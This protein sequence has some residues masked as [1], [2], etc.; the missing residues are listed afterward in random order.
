MASLLC[1]QTLGENNRERVGVCKDGE[2]KG[3]EGR[4]GE[5]A[6]SPVRKI[7]G[8]VVCLGK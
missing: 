1:V 3:V 7:Y 2:G 4:E 5:G 6:L 8:G